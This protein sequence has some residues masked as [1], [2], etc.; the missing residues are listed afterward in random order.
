MLRGWQNLGTI[1]GLI[2]NLALIPF[3]VPN[4]LEKTTECLFNVA[5]ATVIIFSLF[6]GMNNL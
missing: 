2:V 6:F 3:I 4:V 1:L 5:S